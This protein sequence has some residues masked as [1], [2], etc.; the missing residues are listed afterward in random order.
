VRFGDFRPYRAILRGVIRTSKMIRSLRS[1][2]SADGSPAKAGRGEAGILV[3]EL[4]ALV[5]Q[6]S[7]DV[8]AR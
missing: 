7:F 6:S 1:L 2:V 8:G 5:M 4:K 3:D